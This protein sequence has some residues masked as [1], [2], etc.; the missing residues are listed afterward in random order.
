MSTALILQLPDYANHLYDKAK[1]LLK[2][3]VKVDRIV[4]AIELLTQEQVNQSARIE[5]FLKDVSRISFENHNRVEQISNE[6]NKVTTVLD[7]MKRTLDQQ[8][9]MQTWKSNDLTPEQ[10]KAAVQALGMK[11]AVYFVITVP[12]ILIIFSF[13]DHLINIFYLHQSTPWV[14]SSELLW[15]CCAGLFAI[16]AFGW[17]NS[18]FE[19]LDL[20]NVINHFKNKD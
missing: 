3:R 12:T 5:V 19:V 1:G 18:I 7:Q 10:Q 6:M 11:Y 8:N 17:K 15:V 4:K 14:V 20:R 13:I 16:L 2:G 9:I